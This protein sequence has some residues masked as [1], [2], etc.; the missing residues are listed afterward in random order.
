M[1]MPSSPVTRP[2]SRIEPSV[3]VKIKFPPSSTLQ[4]RTPREIA[5]IISA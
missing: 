5:A 3:M 2:K 1:D 4:D